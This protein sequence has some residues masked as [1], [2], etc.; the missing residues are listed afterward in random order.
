MSLPVTIEALD[1]KDIL[2]FLLD[3]IDY[4][5]INTHYRGVVATTFS[6]TLISRTSLVLVFFASLV[7]VGRR[8]LVFATKC[9]NRRGV[10]RFS[11]S[12]VFLLLFCRS[13]PLKILSVNLT[14]TGGRL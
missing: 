4:V 11:P 12:K 13:I 14:G 1:L 5:G 7:L 2:E 10:N 8:L 3:G 6:T 9:V